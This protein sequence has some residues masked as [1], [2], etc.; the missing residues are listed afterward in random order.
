MDSP[1]P[2]VTDFLL[3][4]G[5]PALAAFRRERLVERARACRPGIVDLHGHWIYFARTGDA[6]D[7]IVRRLEELL[8][9]SFVPNERAAA[10]LDAACLASGLARFK[11][12]RAYVFVDGIP[13]S[14]SGKLLRRLLREGA[15]E[16]L[17]DFDSTL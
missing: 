1:A 11:R 3:F 10:A 14:A 12:P 16:V 4:R 7:R 9:A 6:S 5:S 13:R 17:P 15:Y 2:P 8:D